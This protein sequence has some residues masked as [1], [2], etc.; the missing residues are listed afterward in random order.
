MITFHTY[1]THIHLLFFQLLFKSMVDALATGLHPLL[2]IMTNI[3]SP[4]LLLDQSGVSV[5][6][7]MAGR[8]F[9]TSI[10]IMK[11]AKLSP[12]QTTLTTTPRCAGEA[13]TLTVLER[14]LTCFAGTRPFGTQQMALRKMFA[15]VG[16]IW[17]SIPSKIRSVGFIFQYPNFVTN[18]DLRS[19][20]FSLTWTAPM[21]QHLQR[22]RKANW[23]SYWRGRVNQIKNTARNKLS[24]HSAIWLEQNFLQIVQMTMF[25]FILVFP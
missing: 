23:P 15:N 3:A 8:Q 11:C 4:P 25:Y 1:P 6:R 16:R 24:L 2:E 12:I 20:V 7:K 18:S 10:G 14:I 21:K 17:N 19:V 22:Q 13:T 5:R 9:A